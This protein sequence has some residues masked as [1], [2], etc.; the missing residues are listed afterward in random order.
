MCTFVV[1]SER[2]YLTESLLAKS[3]SLFGSCVMGALLEKPRVTW[4]LFRS[5][6][7]KFL[8]R[9]LKKNKKPKSQLSPA[10]PLENGQSGQARACASR[11]DPQVKAYLYEMRGHAQQAVDKYLEL[12]GK[13]KAQLQ[14]NSG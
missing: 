9:N 10:I 7:L 1:V 11:P 8:Q 14:L 4:S 5:L 6:L 12:S 3:L 13:T 2:F